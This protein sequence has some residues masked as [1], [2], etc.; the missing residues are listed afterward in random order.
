MIPPLNNSF[1]YVFRDVS[2]SGPLAPEHLNGVPGLSQRNQQ[3]VDSSRDF[4]ERCCRLLLATFDGAGHF[5]LEQPPTA[6]SWEEPVA[7]LLK[8][9][10]DFIYISACS[11]GVSIHKALAEKLIPRSYH[12]LDYD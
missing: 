1:A 6:M 12:L 4:L 10:V 8:T 7:L 3:L 5:S 9:A 2:N 11:V